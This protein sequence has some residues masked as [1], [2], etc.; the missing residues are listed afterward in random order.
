MEREHIDRRS[1]MKRFGASAGV[2]VALA[3]CSGETDDDTDGSE[4]LDDGSEST[5]GDT[6]DDTL[7]ATEPLYPTTFDPHNHASTNTYQMINQSLFEPL[8]YNDEATDDEGN[9]L[10]DPYPGLATDWEF[11]SDDET[12]LRFYLREGVTFHNGDEFT[13]E[14]VVFTFQRQFDVEESEIGAPGLTELPQYEDMVVVDDEFA[15]DLILSN[16][17]PKTIDRVCGTP[18]IMNE[19]FVEANDPAEDP[20]GTGPYQIEDRTEGEEL[21]YTYY[22]DYWGEEPDFSTVRWKIA[23]ETQ[24]Q[25]SQV[26]AGETDLAVE[27]NPQGLDQLSD[28][29]G[30]HTATTPTPRSVFMQMR[31]VGDDTPFQSKEFRQ[32]MCLA[33]DNEDIVENVVGEYGDPTTTLAPDILPETHPDLEPYPYDPKRAEELVSESGLEG[34]EF[35][36][37]T[38]QGRYLR[39]SEVA[40]AVVEDIDSLSNVSCSVN[41]RDSNSWIS[42]LT[43][44]DASDQPMASIVGWGGA[45]FLVKTAVVQCSLVEGSW[46]GNCYD[47]LEDLIDEANTIEEY[48]PYI[49][50]SREISRW[51]HEEYVNVW[52][53]NSFNLYG[54]SDRVEFDPRIDEGVYPA[55]VRRSE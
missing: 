42:D 27:I 5:S 24:T 30:A 26:Q 8:L 7:V 34:T 20:M 13:P 36:L 39:D 12:E 9:Y 50:A 17:S 16:A 38:P 51:L 37:H 54:M 23:P 41:I 46:G 3:G 6:D 28:Y 11:V 48:D 21:V 22:E 19:A 33:I 31:N 25:V 53:Y 18:V 49:E 35:E 4:S 52:L 14:D 32:A 2:G 43:S 55:M 1:L 44:D 29:D 47:E 45:D 15:V 10:V 40:Q